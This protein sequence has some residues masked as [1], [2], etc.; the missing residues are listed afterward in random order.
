MNELVTAQR[1]VLVPYGRAGLQRLAATYE[2]DERGFE[3]AISRTLEMS[4][5]ECARLGTNARNWFVRN[6]EAFTGRLDAA[7]RAALSR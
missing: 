4:D 5:A 7:L 6:K 3:A 2:F 1:G